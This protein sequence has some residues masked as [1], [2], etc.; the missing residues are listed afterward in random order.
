VTTPGT[1]SA[2]PRAARTYCDFS[3]G[4]NYSGLPLRANMAAL[5]ERAAR[6]YRDQALASEWVAEAPRASLAHGAAGVAYFL[7]RHSSFG[8]GQQSL[9]AAALW[10]LRA[11]RVRGQGGAFVTRSGPISSV[12]G[13]ALHYHEP[14]VWWVRA[15]VAAARN[16]RGQVRRAAAGF[17]EAG[18]QTPGAPWDVTLGA[19]GLLLGCA[20]L[21]ESLEDPVALAPVRAT[22]ERLAAAL[23]ALSEHDG[24]LPG[25]TV[26]G[27]L[28]AAHGWAGVAHALLRWSRAICGPPPAETLALLERLT[29]LRRPSGRWPVRAGS[30]DVYRGW[31]HGSAGWAQLWALASEAT[32][33]HR[34]LGFADDCAQDA[35]AAGGVSASLCCGQAGQGFAALTLYR[36]TGERHWLAAAQRMAADAVRAAAN[37]DAPAHQLFAG[38]LGAVLL[39]AELEDPANAAMPVYETIGCLR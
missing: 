21:V 26:L 30:R 25:E 39:A 8:G 38:E 22:G 27:Y 31:C 11:A 33:E 9:D 5:A 16:D 4:L 1:S 6:R 17:A 2:V 13:G 36:A 24:A 15:L 7:F 3:A 20:Q 29:E 35:V 14:G 32:G 19:A 18:A 12:P 28:G 34:L 37:E 23:A 10:A